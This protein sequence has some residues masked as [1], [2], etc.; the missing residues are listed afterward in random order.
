MK[1]TSKCYKV[2]LVRISNQEYCILHTLT[3]PSSTSSAT[4]KYLICSSSIFH[5]LPYT[6]SSL[7]AKSVALLYL[8]PFFIISLRIDTVSWRPIGTEERKVSNCWQLHHSSLMSHISSPC[9][10][11]KNAYLTTSTIRYKATYCSISLFL[12]FN[13]SPDSWNKK[14]GNWA[15]HDSQLTLAQEFYE[16]I[17]IQPTLLEPQSDPDQDQSLILRWE[18]HYLHSVFKLLLQC[19]MLILLMYSATFVNWHWSVIN[20]N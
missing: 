6:D 13:H 16:A 11:I 7:L 3:R 9:W 19:V 5:L 1:V 10:M 14:S 15:H 2:R 18:W 20:L 12:N 4:E 17:P 8:I